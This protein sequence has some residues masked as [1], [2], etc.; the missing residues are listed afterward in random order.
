[1]RLNKSSFC[2]HEP[3]K[4]PPAAEEHD[5]SS[6]NEAEKAMMDAKRR[7]DM[8]DMA[9]LQDYGKEL[10]SFNCTPIV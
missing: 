10:I 7:Q 8:D 9:K 5:E 6:M 3:V 2:S 4:H 1:M